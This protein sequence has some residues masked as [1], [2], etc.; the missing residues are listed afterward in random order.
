ML[1]TVD[2]GERSLEGYRGIVADSILDEVG[3]CA[4]RLRGV[5]VLHLNATP[6][7]GGVSEILRSTVPLLNDIG[8]VADW[9]VTSGDDAFFH[10]SK[11]IH[12]ALQG[13]E[14]ALGS[15]EWAVYRETV[16]RNAGLLEEE[17]DVVFVHDPQPAGILKLHGKGSARWVWRC[18]ID[19]STP[20][21]EVWEVLA[22]VP[23]R[24]RRRRLHDARV[25]PS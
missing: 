9:K 8:L 23:G 13:A 2:V 17:Y 12:N 19:T 4:E 10:V 1:Q 11:T 21:H 7:G 24:L 22:S 3:A 15:K 20:N 5:R 14:T 6:Y 16:E 25:R 18:H